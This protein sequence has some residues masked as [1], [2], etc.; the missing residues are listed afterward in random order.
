MQ[1]AEKLIEE[2]EFTAAA[3]LL[4]GNGVEP[5]C[6][7][8]RGLLID[9]Y[10][11]LLKTGEYD[12]AIEIIEEM[13]GLKLND[14]DYNCL[15]YL[16]NAWS[17][18]GNHRLREGHYDS[19]IRA[20]KQAIHC[21]DQSNKTLALIAEACKYKALKLHGTGKKYHQD[22]IR[23]TE[24]PDHLSLA[25]D[26]FQEALALNP[27]DVDTLEF[28]GLAYVKQ[29]A[30]YPGD[31][32]ELCDRAIEVSTVAI[33]LDPE[34]PTVWVNRANAYAEKGEHLRAIEDLDEAIE[35]DPENP[36][37]Y[38]DRANV[39][40][41]AANAQTALAKEDNSIFRRKIDLQ[42]MSE[43]DSWYRRHY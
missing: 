32:E 35:L 11:G 34:R 26:D 25:I 15:H 33:Q 18:Y 29:I 22:E 6:S 24:D 30:E 7:K 19:A 42:I 2:G 8:A 38:Y 36:D 40:E 9:C 4:F 23:K 21:N 12:D 10:T 43:S 37:L 27:K 1:E 39:R 14:P 41:A 28:A 3:W 16:R 20:L 17:E 5:D 13:I 31:K